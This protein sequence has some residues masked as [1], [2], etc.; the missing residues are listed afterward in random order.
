MLSRDRPARPLRDRRAGLVEA[1]WSEALAEI[2]ARVAGVP[3][4]RIG[5]LGGARLANED[6]YAW[7][8][9]ARTVLHTDNVD[10]QLG[11]GLPGDLIASLP[12][13]TIDQVC[14]ASLIVTI[15]PDIKE[16]L[17][18]LYLRLRHAAVDKGVPDHRDEPGPDRAFF[19]GHRV[20]ALPAG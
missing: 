2:A 13:A 4:E 6:A 18:V 12:R 1:T 15:A 19:P 17:P 8:K 14:D 9:L 11:D 3:G 20:L 16:E 10:A 7:A 5:V